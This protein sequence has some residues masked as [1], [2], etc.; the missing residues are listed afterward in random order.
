MS[1]ALRRATLNVLVLGSRRQECR[2]TSQRSN[3]TATTR[4]LQQPD[5][6]QQPPPRMKRC[7]DELNW[8]ITPQ[9]LVEWTLRH[10][11]DAVEDS[12]AGDCAL[13]GCLCR[14]LWWR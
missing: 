1:F 8:R 6:S 10:M 14:A 11:A 2:S 9:E 5:K 3:V 7:Y 13:S 12:K 4:C